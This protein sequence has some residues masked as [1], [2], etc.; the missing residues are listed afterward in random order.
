MANN[1]GILQD[2]TQILPGQVVELAEIAGKPDAQVRSVIE[3]HLADP[4]RGVLKSAV[5]VREEPGLKR[6]SG[7]P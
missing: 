5:P 2:R 4:T 1:L 3:A 6:L 7:A